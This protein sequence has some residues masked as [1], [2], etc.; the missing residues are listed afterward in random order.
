MIYADF[1]YYLNTYGGTK[2]DNDDIFRRIANSASREI[3]LVTFGNI[4]VDDNVQ[5]CCCE[6]ADII[7][8]N[9]QATSTASVYQSQRVGDYS[10]TYFSRKDAL[11]SMRAEIHDSISKWLLLRGGLYR[12]IDVAEG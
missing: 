8:R 11:V 12:G 2:I 7:S 10:V 9:E 6:L 3:D 1:D 5:M 4:D